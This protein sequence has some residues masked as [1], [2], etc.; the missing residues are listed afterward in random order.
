MRLELKNQNKKQPLIIK[1]FNLSENKPRKL[2]EPKEIQ[3]TFEKLPKLN[4]NKTCLSNIEENR[5]ERLEKIRKEIKEK[6]NIK[7]FEFAS[8][9]RPTNLNKIKEEVEKKFESTLQFNNKYVNPD[10]DYS[11]HKGDVKYNEAGLFRE[12]FNINR[13]K[14]NEENELKRKL[15]EKTDSSEYERYLSENRE[16]DN[17]L[18]MQKVE[19]RK[20]ELGMVRE[21]AVSYRVTRML[22]NR[23]HVLEHKKQEE[24][25][26]KKRDEKKKK[27]IAKKREL[28]L[29]IENEH[30]NI[31]K[32]K[33][34][35]EKENKENYKNYR[36]EFNIL[37]LISK[38]EEKILRDRRD[39]LIRQIRELEKLPVKR[40]SGF[41]PSETP[42]YGLLEEMSIIE[43]KER[44]DIQKKMH[45][46]EIKS[47]R[48]ENKL[49]MNE[50]T[51]EMIERAN[52]IM[53]YRDK[54]RN[55]REIKKQLKLDEIKS[56][57]ELKRQIHEQN[58]F[59]VKNKLE[60][61]RE[62]LR[63]DD[64]KF[65]KKIHELSLQRQFL[66]QGRS[67]VE[68]RIFRTMEDGMEKKVNN[69]QNQD[70]F[71]QQ[72]K[73][74][75]K[76][77]DLKLRYKKNLEEVNRQ[78]NLINGYKTNY[79]LI[80][81]LNQN[82]LNEDKKYIKAVHDREISD[83]LYRKKL[84]KERNKYSDQFDKFRIKNKESEI[85][86][87]SPMSFTEG[88]VK[89]ESN[90]NINDD[91]DKNPI[92]NKLENEALEENNNQEEEK[93]EEI[94]A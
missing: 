21:A 68:E 74:R 69:R 12:E 26:L 29:Q 89:M 62:K 1:P 75:I 32:N 14:K 82:Y 67:V 43:L 61:K 94:A 16:R 27:E 6:Y 25:N 88:N 66:K 36:N 44:L 77:I 41:D 2:K 81:N 31:Y 18:N 22:K 92:M 9:K 83:N 7:P 72:K 90:I 80:S 51:D 55:E 49:K 63:K 57:E 10:I 76:W 33:E 78:R 13:N 37:N 38:Q 17:I 28:V 70:L 87:R 93:K 30:D 86:S 3:T 58:V 23:V 45:E 20:L 35:R 91:D 5:I 42:G 73:D 52:F 39:D 79:E 53:T 40:I 11:K 54:M 46:D 47:K 65:L 60:L 85:R 71:D 59:E 50:R 64:E 4:Y 34:K 15:I 8:E 56:Q 84:Y 19:K 24:L 48:E